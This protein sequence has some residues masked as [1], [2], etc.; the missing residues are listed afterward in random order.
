MYMHVGE[1]LSCQRVEVLCTL[2]LLDHYMLLDY[3]NIIY[4][5]VDIRVYSHYLEELDSLSAAWSYLPF[6]SLFF[7]AVDPVYNYQSADEKIYWRIHKT[8][9]WNLMGLSIISG[10]VVVFPCYPNVQHYKLTTKLH[11][12]C[13]EECFCSITATMLWACFFKP[14]QRPHVHLH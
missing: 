14:N 8:F 12:S 10:R 13:R 11:V 2:K 3:S 9:F 1:K 5:L 6:P 4:I 7:F